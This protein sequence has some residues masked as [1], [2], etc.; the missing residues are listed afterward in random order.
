MTS[1]A[2][3]V[4]RPLG[5]VKKVCDANHIVVFDSDGSHILNK[6]AN[7]VTWLREENG[8]YVMDLWVA[9]PSDQPFTRQRKS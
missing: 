6:G 9:P 3:P 2:A 7:E 1:Q 8:N 4:D 5:S